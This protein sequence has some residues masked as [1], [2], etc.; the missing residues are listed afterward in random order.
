MLVINQRYIKNQVGYY[1]RAWIE[2]RDI[3]HVCARTNKFSLGKDHYDKALYFH[4]KMQT[5]EDMMRVYFV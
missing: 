3:A 2:A 1:R 5:F 4:K